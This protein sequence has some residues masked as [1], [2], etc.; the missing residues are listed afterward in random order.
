MSN[1]A[2]DGTAEGVNFSHDAEGVAGYVDG[3]PE[4]DGEEVVGFGEGDAFEL[5]E[6]AVAGVVH[7]DVDSAE[8]GDCGVEGGAD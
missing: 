5:A 2:A 6:E 8:F 7:D 4:V 3:G 1:H